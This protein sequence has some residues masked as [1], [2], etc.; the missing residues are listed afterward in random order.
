MFRLVASSSLRKPMIQIEHG[1]PLDSDFGDIRNILLVGNFLISLTEN[2]IYRLK[3]NDPGVG[4]LEVL[5][6]I[7]SDATI[8]K[9]P[10]CCFNK[11]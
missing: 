4:L 6:Y 10:K 1:K 2:E 11:A 8:R 9:Q 7:Y 3:V 5:R